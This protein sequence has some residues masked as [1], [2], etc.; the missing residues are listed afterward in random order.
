M[1]GVWAVNELLKLRSPKP[2]QLVEL[3]PG[4]GTLVQDVLRVSHKY[5]YL[6]AHTHVFIFSYL[7]FIFIYVLRYE[8]IVCLSKL[9]L[10]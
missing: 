5:T 10:D 9:F 6:Q 3:G 2:L 7:K 4:R 1:V 8:D